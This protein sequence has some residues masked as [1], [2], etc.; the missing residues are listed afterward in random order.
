[1]SSSSHTD[2]TVSR[3]EYDLMRLEANQLALMQIL[4]NKGILGSTNAMPYIETSSN[5]AD[6]DALVGCSQGNGKKNCDA[7]FKVSGFIDD[8]GKHVKT[9]AG[10]DPFTN[11]RLPTDDTQS[12]PVDKP[13]PIACNPTSN[14]SMSGCLA[15]WVHDDIQRKFVS[16]C[17]RARKQIEERK[18]TTDIS[19]SG[20]VSTISQSE[21][22]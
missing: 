18:R 11:F 9:D 10:F 22:T 3:V 4:Q 12:F 21:L 17:K 6:L 2:V 19:S 5:P 13:L 20:S 7:C 15:E 8:H 1:M 14:S 16:A